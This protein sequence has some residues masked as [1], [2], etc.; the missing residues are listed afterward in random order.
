MEPPCFGG[1]ESSKPFI[2]DCVSLY[3]GGAYMLKLCFPESLAVSILDA[4]E[5]P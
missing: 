1:D 5:I 4:L 2:V 3:N